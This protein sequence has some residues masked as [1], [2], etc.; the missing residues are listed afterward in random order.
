[1]VCIVR[2]DEVKDTAQVVESQQL[3]NVSLQ[4]D[5]CP[6]SPTRG[7]DP[8]SGSRG[9]ETKVNLNNSPICEACSK[10]KASGGP[11]KRNQGCQ[12]TSGGELGLSGGF[13][14][15][16]PP[17]PTPSRHHE[18]PCRL[19]RPVLSAELDSPKAF[20]ACRTF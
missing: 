11:V 1:V 10:A 20:N 13:F 9:V 14:I 17:F 8:S 16:E 19:H 5:D 3:N 2:S 6:E 12:A 7:F 18:L 15:R 4:S